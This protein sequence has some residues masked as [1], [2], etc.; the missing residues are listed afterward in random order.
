[1]DRQTGQVARGI[2]HVPLTQKTVTA[3]DEMLRPLAEI[4]GRDHIDQFVENLGLRVED[5]LKTMNAGGQFNPIA[6]EG[7]WGNL[8]IPPS[9]NPSGHQ[10]R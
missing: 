3:W 10:S 1:M 2:T 9:Y 5:A 6:I 7:E 4:V 8:T